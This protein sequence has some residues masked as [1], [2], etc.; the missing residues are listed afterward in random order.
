MLLLLRCFSLLLPFVFPLAIDVNERGKERVMS[1]S[2][3]LDSKTAL[4][5]YIDGCIVFSKIR[6]G[7][8]QNRIQTDIYVF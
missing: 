8:V 7:S 4:F 6:L 1:V 5:Y 2:Y 3:L